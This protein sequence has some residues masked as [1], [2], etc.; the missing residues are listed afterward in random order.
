MCVT[1]LAAAFRSS[2]A[3]SSGWHRK[4]SRRSLTKRYNWFKDVVSEAFANNESFDDAVDGQV[5]YGIERDNSMVEQ[6]RRL[7]RYESRSST[8]QVA[9]IDEDKLVGTKWSMNMFLAGIPDTDPNNN[10]FGSKVNISSQD[11][12]FGIGV[13]VP[14]EPTV[15]IEIE[16]REN[17]ICRVSESDFTTEGDGQWRLF[18]GNLLRLGV[19][20]VGY[21]RRVG[22]TGTL[23]K[24]YWSD[25]DE[26]TTQASSTYSIP[27]GFVYADAKVLY[28]KPGEFLMDVTPDSGTK[29][30]ID[31]LGLLRV[32]KKE[33]LLGSRVNMVACGAFTAS[34]I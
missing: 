29:N 25:E 17:G 18:E 7:A 31:T 10:L 27:P 33:G 13:T 9:P 19:E 12:R 11:K 3:Y 34:T 24:V 16:L 32:E 4:G 14:D 8:Q 1:P 22:V 30:S 2:F 21:Q 26:V 23:S 5:D 20:C 6:Q 28:G 15:T